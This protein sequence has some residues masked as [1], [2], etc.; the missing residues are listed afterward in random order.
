MKGLFNYLMKYKGYDLN[1]LKMYY[2][3]VP[4]ISFICMLYLWTVFDTWLIVLLIK[5][6]LFIGV[7]IYFINWYFWIKN[8]YGNYFVWVRKILQE[9]NDN[10]KELWYY[11]FKE[12][13]E[14]VNLHILDSLWKIYIVLYIL[15][16]ITSLF[17]M[18]ISRTLISE[19]F[20]LM[21]LFYIIEV[22]IL[23]INEYFNSDIKINNNYNI[24]NKK[25]L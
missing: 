5:I 22:V 18:Y 7:F 17:I 8:A 1:M 23:S 19:T 12:N 13:P 24:K 10:D 16:I 4:I 3:I 21:I 2:I 25:E 11:N 6:L 14:E 15:F 9:Y 20:L